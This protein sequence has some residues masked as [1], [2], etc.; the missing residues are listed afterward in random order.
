MY[1]FR[2]WNRG[3]GD[4]KRVNE[5][6]WITNGDRGWEARRRDRK[7]IEEWNSEIIIVKKK[8]KQRT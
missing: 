2:G 7:K 3:R 1:F 6:R 8:I 5:E 4:K